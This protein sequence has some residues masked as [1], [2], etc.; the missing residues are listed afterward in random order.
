MNKLYNA[1]D[2]FDTLLDLKKVAAVQRQV[3][4]PTETKGYY[5]T[6]VYLTGRVHPIKL[7]YPFTEAGKV[8]WD[9]DYV[10]LTLRRGPF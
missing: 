9:E 8:K 1:N 10:S 6:S 4:I 5:R 3:Y 7:L 2:D